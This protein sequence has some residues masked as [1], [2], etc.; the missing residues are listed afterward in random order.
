MAGEDIVVCTQVRGS[1]RTI[2]KLGDLFDE[3]AVFVT[4]EMAI[5]GVLVKKL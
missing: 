3:T 1:G 4:E 2:G 5:R